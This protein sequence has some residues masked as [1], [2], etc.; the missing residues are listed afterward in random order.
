LYAVDRS[1]P[2]QLSSAQSSSWI[3]FDGE[4]VVGTGRHARTLGLTPTVIDHRHPRPS[5]TGT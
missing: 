5:R 4:H 3:R 2:S 1:L